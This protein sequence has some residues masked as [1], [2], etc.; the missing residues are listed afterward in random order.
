LA[1]ISAAKNTRK[2]SA[3]TFEVFILLLRNQHYYTRDVI[4]TKMMYRDLLYFEGIR[5]KTHR[6]YKLHKNKHKIMQTFYI[7]LENGP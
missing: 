4:G 1:N 2:Q 7:T 5:A 3:V 6:E